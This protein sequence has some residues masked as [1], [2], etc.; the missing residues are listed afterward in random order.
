MNSHATDLQKNGYCVVPNVLDESLLAQLRKTFSDERL[1]QKSTDNFSSAGGFFV[2]DYTD[3]TVV[4]LLTLPTMFATLQ[5]MGFAS[6][7]V[8]SY[9]V[10][11]KPPHAAGLSWH[12]DLFYEW[13]Q[14][15]P[16]ELFLIYYLSDTTPNNGCLRVV[17][18][19]HRWPQ[20]MLHEQA[21]DSNAR[22]DEVDVPVKAGDL[23][24]GD[25]RILHATHPNQENSWRTCLTIAYVPFFNELP[26]PIKARIV[27]NP[28]L[29]PQQSVPSSQLASILPTYSGQ[30]TPIGLID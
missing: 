16:A 29:P 12:S 13:S 28:C 9:Y 19:S 20:A 30:A 23:F 6:P 22:P 21:H 10:S 27:Q 1:A 11:T 17:P 2:L 5:A 25:R 3:P 24:I 18:G 26:E 7:K 8:H 14:P 15:E 4:N